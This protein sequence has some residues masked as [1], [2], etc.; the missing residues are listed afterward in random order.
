MILLT[1]LALAATAQ[2]SHAWMPVDSSKKLLDSRGFSLFDGQNTTDDEAHSVG[3]RWMPAAGKIRGVNLGSLFV[4]EPWMAN[5]EW[6]NM[7]C[8][9][10]KSEFD[11]VMNIG[12]DKADA[13]FQKHWGSWITQTDLDE[14]MG[15]GINTIRIPL[16]YWLDES[17]VDKNSEHFPRVGVASREED[18]TRWL[19]FARELRST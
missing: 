3:K 5:T 15:Y 6:N 14:M 4:F 16:G 19:S 1:V 13:A 2:L 18:L 12:Q 17:L 11:C 9:G 10:Q 8:G 7:G